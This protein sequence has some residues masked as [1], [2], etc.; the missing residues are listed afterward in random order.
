[1]EPANACLFGDSYHL[2]GRSPNLSLVSHKELT[3]SEAESMAD[4]DK[5]QIL[6]GVQAAYEHVETLEDAFE[7][8]DEGYVNFDR[9]LDSHGGVEYVGVEYGAGENSYG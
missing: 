3:Y 4:L 2:I 9:Y 5:A 8:V 1:Y 6:A 7:A